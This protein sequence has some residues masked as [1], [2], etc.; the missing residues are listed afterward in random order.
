VRVVVVAGKGGVAGEAS[1]GD[2]ADVDLDGCKGKHLAT[3]SGRGEGGG[4]C[5]WWLHQRLRP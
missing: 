4:G 2:V 5:G 1:L 3:L